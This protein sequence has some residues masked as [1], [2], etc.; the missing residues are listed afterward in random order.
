MVFYTPLDLDRELIKYQKAL[1][2]DFGGKKYDDIFEIIS[3][4]CPHI[5]SD[6]ELKDLAVK[7]MTAIRE[8]YGMRGLRVWYHSAKKNL[9]LKELCKDEDGWGGDDFIERKYFKLIPHIWEFHNKLMFES[10]YFLNY[11]RYFRLLENAYYDEYGNLFE[12]VWITD[13]PDDLYHLMKAI[14]LS[15]YDESVVKSLLPVIKDHL[16][17]N[18][19]NYYLSLDLTD[20]NVLRD[21]YLHLAE[22]VGDE[23]AYK[24]FDMFYS[25]DGWGNTV[26]DRWDVTKNP[27][28]STTSKLIRPET[29]RSDYQNM[30]NV[31]L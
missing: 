13:C 29:S 8:E 27:D 12:R 5:K 9:M 19:C 31:W 21:I 20:E 16:Y 23:D 22:E 2:L 11:M 30:G 3:K 28:G 7:N 14:H 15:Y 18:N 24:G 17:Y 25:N 26:F 1:N 6:K 4:E 10:E